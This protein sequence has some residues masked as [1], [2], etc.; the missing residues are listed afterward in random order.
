[1]QIWRIPKLP[2]ADFGMDRRVPV[3]GEFEQRPLFVWAVT[4]QGCQIKR[5]VLA[6]FR[7]NDEKGSDSVPEPLVNQTALYWF[8]GKR[9]LSPQPLS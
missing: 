8:G 3:D 2:P 9:R 1:M 7:N 5:V 4:D 6:E